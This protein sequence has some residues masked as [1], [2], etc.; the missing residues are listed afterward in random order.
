MCFCAHLSTFIHIAKSRNFVTVAKRTHGDKVLLTRNEVRNLTLKLLHKI[1]E[2]PVCTTCLDVS[3]L[4]LTQAL[5]LCI[6]YSFIR[7]VVC[8]TTGQWLLPKRVLRSVR[9]DDP[10]YSLQY[11]LVSV[12]PSNSCLHLLPR[13]PVASI[14]PSTLLLTTCFNWQFAR[15]M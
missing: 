13:L 10:S 3:K 6:S 5:C 2:L 7:S 12:G 14:L 1:T 11:P 15:K 8:L 9:S 4:Y